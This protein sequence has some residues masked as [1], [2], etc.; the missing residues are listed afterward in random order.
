MKVF[1]AHSV[2]LALNGK[3]EAELDKLESKGIIFPAQFSKWATPRG[4]ARIVLQLCLESYT[5]LTQ[6]AAR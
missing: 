5:K 6:A 2:P 4:G 1:K 3:I